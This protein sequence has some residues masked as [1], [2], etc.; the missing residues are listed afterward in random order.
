[1]QFIF[2]GTTTALV[3]ANPP[4]DL[5][6]KVRGDW[7]KAQEYYAEGVFRSL[8]RAGTGVIGICEADSR[9]QL[10]AL[11]AELPMVTAGYVVLE[12]HEL[13]PYTGF[14]PEFS[15]RQQSATA[16]CPGPRLT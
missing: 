12:L 5:M 16:P 14:A 2:Q 6:D 7:S 10:E 1:M 11:M 15:H 3:Q 4:P 9:A 13:T 8:W